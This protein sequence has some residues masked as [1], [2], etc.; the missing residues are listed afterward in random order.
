MQVI[1]TFI[2]KYHIYDDVKKHNYL[3]GHQNQK[4]LIQKGIV[5]I[6]NAEWI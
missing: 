2:C 5:L 1:I 6:E 4:I 3:C